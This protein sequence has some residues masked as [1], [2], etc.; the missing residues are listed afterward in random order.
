MPIVLAGSGVYIGAFTGTFSFLEMTFS[1]RKMF[2]SYCKET[3]TGSKAL[4]LK[5]VQCSDYIDRCARDSQFS[6]L[7][8]DQDPNKAVARL[9]EVLVNTIVE[10]DAQWCVKLKWL[11]FASYNKERY[12]LSEV[13]LAFAGINMEGHTFSLTT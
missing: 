3:C 9:A 7:L 6:T 11:K 8:S 4:H 5:V 13:S 10:F 2:I 12:A 1:Y